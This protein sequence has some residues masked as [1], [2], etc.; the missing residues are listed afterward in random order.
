MEWH[1]GDPDKGKLS[2]DV[3]MF[4]VFFSFLKSEFVVKF[5]SEFKEIFTFVP[6]FRLIILHSFS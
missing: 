6:N 3:V 4:V 5:F 1:F 2:W